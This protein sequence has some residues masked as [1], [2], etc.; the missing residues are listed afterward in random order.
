[1]HNP[2]RLVPIRSALARLFH[3]YKAETRTLS[4]K[5]HN[6]CLVEVSFVFALPFLSISEAD[7]FAIHAIR[8]VLVGSLGEAAI[9]PSLL[10]KFGRRSRKDC[11][12]GE[13]GN[14]TTLQARNLALSS[15]DL[16]THIVS[17]RYC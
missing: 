6:A 13:A 14:G 5:Y 12:G 3:R 10:W 11:R 4:E 17:C 7:L 15:I 1:M 9:G 2:E 16:T 8:R